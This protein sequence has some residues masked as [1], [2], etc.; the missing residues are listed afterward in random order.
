MSMLGL[1]LNKSLPL[2]VVSTE[3]HTV[4]NATSHSHD[5]DKRTLGHHYHLHYLF[6]SDTQTLKL[7]HQQRKGKEKLG[8]ISP[9]TEKVCILNISARMTMN[10]CKWISF[11]S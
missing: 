4:P 10:R 9:L 11:T 8:Q 1:D 6:P 3:P 5:A 7:Y 2:V